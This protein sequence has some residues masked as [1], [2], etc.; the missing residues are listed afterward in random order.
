MLCTECSNTIERGSKIGSLP[1]PNAKLCVNCRIAH[2][3]A[4]QPEVSP[5][6]KYF[7]TPALDAYMREHYYGGLNQR[8]KVINTLMR[9]TAFPRWYIKKQAAR[10][11][12]TLHPD[13]RAW[14]PAELNLL[15][16]WVGKFSTATIAKRLHRTETSVVVKLKHMKI[17]RRVR[18]GY[19]MRQLELCFG[20]DHHKIERWIAQGWLTDKRQG[21]KRKP[22]S[23]GGDIHRFKE[24]AIL[25]F[26][27][28]HPQ[29]INL[30]KVD[31]LWFLDLVLLHGS[32]CC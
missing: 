32:E 17:S 21:T 7:W 14:T 13:R 26:I 19:T 5:R 12:L 25:E 22:T 20:E 27:R 16:K 9:Q 18:N 31:Q 15:D 29:E 10:L 8:F 1:G 6:K 4:G 30:G 11:G 2:Q 24:C 23:Q 28:A 3:R